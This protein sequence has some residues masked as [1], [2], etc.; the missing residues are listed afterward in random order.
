MHGELVVS[1]LGMPIGQT[2]ANTPI[3]PTMRIQ[4]AVLNMRVTPTLIIG[5]ANFMVRETSSR[6]SLEVIQT[7]ATWQPLT[8][9]TGVHRL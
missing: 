1:A 5:D 4:P 3:M 6:I 7:L 8:E 2:V 9:I